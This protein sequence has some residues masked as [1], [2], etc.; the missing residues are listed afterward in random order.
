MIRLFYLNRKTDQKAFI[1]FINEDRM[2]NFI[3]EYD[4]LVERIEYIS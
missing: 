1:F 3:K 2:Y 4:I